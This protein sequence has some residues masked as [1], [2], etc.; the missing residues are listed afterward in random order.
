MEKPIL[1]SGEMVT[2]IL[3]GRKTMTRRVMHCQPIDQPMPW[4]YDPMCTRELGWSGQTNKERGTN[5]T[6]SWE[7][8]WGQSG[9]HLWVR[10]FSAVWLARYPSRVKPYRCDPW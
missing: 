6:V 9:D 8:P 10:A 2:A 7:C 1:F 4:I 5:I 3:D